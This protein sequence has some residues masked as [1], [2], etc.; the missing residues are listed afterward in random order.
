MALL[1]EDFG[2]DVDRSL[3]GALDFK[4]LF[5]GMDRSVAREQIYFI[6]ACRATSDTMIEA[7]GN[8]G[9]VVI[10][11]S[12]K[13][14]PSRP[15]E[16]SVYFSTLAGAKAYG[17][18][19]KPSMFTA[20]LLTGLDGAG[21]DDSEGDWRVD[22]SRLHIAINYYMRKAVEEGAERRQVPEF[23]GNS[24]LP[25]HY[26]SK[27]PTVPVSVACEPAEAQ[28]KA[29]LSYAPSVRLSSQRMPSSDPWEIELPAG[30]YSFAA[31]FTDDSYR[32]RPVE[33]WVRPVYTK[34][35]IEVS[36]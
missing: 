31:R 28:E 24:P 23:G 8:S 12:G 2:S 30:K 34:V 19:G 29:H 9:Q 3:G 33:R 15:R 36:P 25:I 21:S 26:L 14:K 1:L 10:Q 35:P 6:D 22:T 27:A 18:E 11:P 16:H 32:S 17:R 5:L 13:D 20:A 4:L 7:Q